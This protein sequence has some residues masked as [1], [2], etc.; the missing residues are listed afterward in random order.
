MCL[1][2]MDLNNKENL[3][4]AIYSLVLAKKTEFSKEDI[5]RE[6]EKFQKLDVQKLEEQTGTLLKTWVSAGL[7][8]QRWNT[9]SAVL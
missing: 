8:K 5:V 4:F 1:V 2:G 9:F 3:E 6:V 7:I